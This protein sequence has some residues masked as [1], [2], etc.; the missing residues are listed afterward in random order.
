[1]GFNYNK[2]RGKIREIFGTEY[3][4]AR[5]ME[6]SKNSLSDKVNNKVE[7]T[8]KEIEKAVKLLRIPKEEIPM[9]FFTPE[10]QFPELM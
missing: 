1:M 8:Q 2:L 7:F 4:F 9:Y 3:K 5:A 10:V 6:M